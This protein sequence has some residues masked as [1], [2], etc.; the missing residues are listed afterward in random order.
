[1]KENNFIWE[2]GNTGEL[3]SLKYL[4]DHV[5]KLYLLRLK[6]K[7]CGGAKMAA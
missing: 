3:I 4:S 2:G 7:I 1:M 6:I 5:K